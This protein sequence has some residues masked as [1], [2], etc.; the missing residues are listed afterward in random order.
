M[1]P[2][3]IQRKLDINKEALATIKLEIALA[4]YAMEITQNSIKRKYPP[5]VSVYKKS[6]IEDYEQSLREFDETMA[7]TITPDTPGQYFFGNSIQRVVDQQPSNTIFH[8]YRTPPP[9]E[10]SDEWCEIIDPVSM[11]IDIDLEYL[12]MLNDLDLD[13]MDIGFG[14]E[15]EYMNSLPDDD[16]FMHLTVF[17]D[18]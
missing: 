15:W 13:A 16:E 14:S 10:T 6:R 9:E 17:Q 4:E 1:F 5:T 3:Q 2:E 11:D 18:S 7:D 8:D 12:A